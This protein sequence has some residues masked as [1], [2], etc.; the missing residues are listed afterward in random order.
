MAWNP[1]DSRLEA[2]TEPDGRAVEAKSMQQRRGVSKDNQEHSEKRVKGTSL[3]CLS[4]YGAREHLVSI[5]TFLFCVG[6]PRPEDN[7]W[8]ICSRLPPCELLGRDL[9]RNV[10]IPTEPFCQ[11]LF[12]ILFKIYS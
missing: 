6:A 12:S 3:S 7:L 11:L 5:V 8:R 4:H 1:R 2:E 9:V 10:L